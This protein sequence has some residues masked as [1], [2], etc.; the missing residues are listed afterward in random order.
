MKEEVRRIIKMVEEGKLSAEDAAE[1]IEA[2]SGGST[3]ESGSTEEEAAPEEPAQEA[4]P[5]S[6]TP[7]RTRP[8]RVCSAEP[9]TGTAPGCSIPRGAG[10]AVRAP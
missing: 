6:A 8:R 9:G 4:D 5:L 2:F 10:A 3:H 1:L 7:S